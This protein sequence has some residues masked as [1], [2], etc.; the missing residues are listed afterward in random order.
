MTDK[1]FSDPFYATGFAYHRAVLVD[2]PGWWIAEGSVRPVLRAPL[3]DLHAEQRN[4]TWRV[5]A[6]N[7]GQHYHTWRYD[8]PSNG[9]PTDQDPLYAW[10]IANWS[11]YQ[12]DHTT[13]TPTGNALH[14]SHRHRC[15]H[16]RLVGCLDR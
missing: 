11:P 14:Y 12:D 2:G 9:V 13:I 15:S 3:P 1:L 6:G 16:L 10:N 7:V 8:Q 4:P 5:E